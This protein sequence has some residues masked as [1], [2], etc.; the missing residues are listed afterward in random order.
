MGLLDVPGSDQIDLSVVAMA[1]VMI[2]VIVAMIIVAV[3]MPIIV[4]VSMRVAVIPMVFVLAVVIAVVVMAFFVE[5]IAVE[6]VFPTAVPA[7]IGTLAATR[8][9]SAVSE[10]RIVVMVDVAVKT[11]RPAEPRS[12]AKKHASGKPL[13]AVIAK[14]R[15]LVRRVIEIAV[16]ASR[17]DS[18]A[19]ADLRL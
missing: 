12:R 18:D 3:P 9:R 19:D 10:M 13:W 8:K 2:V 4:P 16:G 6:L 15:T 11:F 7:P 17:R 1:V 14:R 5:F